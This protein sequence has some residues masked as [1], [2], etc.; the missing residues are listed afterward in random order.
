MF[1]VTF[2]GGSGGVTTLYS[3]DDQGSNGAP[4]LTQATPSGVNGF[5]DMQFQ[6][7]GSDGLFYLVNSYK[8]S[9][10]VLPIAPG[11]TTVPT[12]F[13]SGEAAAVCSVY[14][15]FGLAFDSTLEVLYV[16][17]QDSNVVVRVYGPNTTSP[18][19]VPGQP[20]PVNP[21]L[22][23]LFSNPTFL[24]GTFV[25]SQVPLAPSGCATPTAVSSAQGGLNASPSGLKPTQ[26]PSN[27]VRGVAVIGSTLYVADEVENLTRQ[28]DT[29]TGAYLGAIA[30]SSGLVLSPGHLLVSAGLLYITVTPGAAAA[31]VLCY[32]PAS[33]TL[34][35]V[36]DRSQQNLDVKHPS[37]ITFD[38]NGNFYLADLD[39]KAVYQFDSSFNPT[40]D[41]FI[42]A[43]P[44][45]PEFI[46]WVN[47]AWLQSSAPV[48]E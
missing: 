31:L 12:P 4:Y 19:A 40:G 44:D 6:P 22:L 11:A 5:R 28:Y 39:G 35:P 34:S 43:M 32:D 46:L 29:S 33:S 18:G 16:S 25:A 15:P 30:D 17:N 42:S 20:M 7:P 37:G 47:D 9:S 24:P 13:V 2:H 26:T 8:E 38:G 41:R 27:S 10:E 14:H 36:V 45:S 23:Q 21:A 48:T 1:I 3:Y